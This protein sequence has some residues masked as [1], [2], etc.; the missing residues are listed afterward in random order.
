MAKQSEEL[1]KWLKNAELINRSAL[2]KL[3]GI[4]RANLDK[5]IIR[6][7]IPEKHIEPLAK[8]L[9][10]YGYIQSVQKLVDEN[11]KPGNRAKIEKARDGDPSSPKSD[12][13]LKL[14]EI[15]KQFSN[16]Q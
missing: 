10:E 11:N 7:D 14:E 6:G 16:G 8:A 12:M 15:K 4:D 9:A 5:Y 13:Q 2:C 3:T 1:A